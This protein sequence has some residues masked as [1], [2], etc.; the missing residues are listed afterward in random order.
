MSNIKTGTVKWFSKSKGFG[1]IEQDSG[2]DVFAHFSSI[3]TDGFKTLIEGQK[4][5][6]VV[7]AGDKGPQA[8]NIVIKSSLSSPRSPSPSEAG[9]YFSRVQ[10]YFRRLFNMSN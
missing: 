3:I 6:F 8:D 7:I 4:V 2:T 9:S 10:M 1:F 5:E